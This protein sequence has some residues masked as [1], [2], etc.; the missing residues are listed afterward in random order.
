MQLGKTNAR[1]TKYEGR[2]DEHVLHVTIEETDDEF[3][4]YLCLDDYGFTDYMFGAKKAYR[5]KADFIKTV[6]AYLYHPEIVEGYLY[7]IERLEQEL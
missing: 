3:N 1:L 2:A 7:D 5:T 4:A 6:E